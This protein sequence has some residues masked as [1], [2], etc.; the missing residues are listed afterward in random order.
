MGDDQGNIIYR[1]DV[2]PH[3]GI[4]LVWPVK[5]GVSSAKMTGASPPPIVTA[6]ES[7][8]C[9]SRF[10]WDQF[11]PFYRLLMIALCSIP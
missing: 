4:D 3:A 11:L 8:A 10:E 7:S 1:R 9:E 6:R 2:D 5:P